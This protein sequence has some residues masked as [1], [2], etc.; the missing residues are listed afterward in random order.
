MS[1]QHVRDI[2]VDNQTA[3][4]LFSDIRKRNIGNEVCH[5]LVRYPSAD[6]PGWVAERL[7][8]MPDNAIGL[9]FL[10]LISTSSQIAHSSLDTKDAV[11]IDIDTS[12]EIANTVA[13]DNS[14]AG[15]CL[16]LGGNVSQPRSG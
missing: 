8:A 3:C 9:S 16:R 5:R 15:S 7:L 6:A 13:N 10:K 4:L 2:S 11:S 12:E 14:M 1:A